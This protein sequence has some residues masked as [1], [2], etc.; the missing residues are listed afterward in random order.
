[1]KNIKIYPMQSPR[2]NPVPNQV[3]IQGAKGLYFQSYQTVIAFKPCSGGP[4]VLDPKWGYS[5]TTT[6][7]CLQ[8]LGERSSKAVQSGIKSGK[9]VAQSLNK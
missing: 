5:K 4:T 1:M 2:G 8:F 3:E 6:R 9:Y 7:Y